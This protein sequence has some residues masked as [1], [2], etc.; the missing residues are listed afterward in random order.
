MQVGQAWSGATW[1]FQLSAHGPSQA[2]P[3]VPGTLPSGGWAVDGQQLGWTCLSQM[4]TLRSVPRAKRRGRR[5]RRGAWRAEGQGQVKGLGWREASRE[6]SPW[7]HL[8]QVR[9]AW[10]LRFLH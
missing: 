9:E 6:V 3:P 2:A 4:R 7:L 8:R 10:V 5:R 1:S